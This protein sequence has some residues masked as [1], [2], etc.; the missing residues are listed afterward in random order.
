MEIEANQK[1]LHS[2]SV[3]VSEPI[4]TVELNITIESLKRVNYLIFLQVKIGVCMLI[5]TKSTKF[6]VQSLRNMIALFV[7]GAVEYYRFL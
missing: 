4:F 1:Y 2:W 6:I 3:N 7:E 5:T